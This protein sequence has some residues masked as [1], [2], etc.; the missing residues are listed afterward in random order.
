[1]SD[2]PETFF[3]RALAD[4]HL[5]FSIVMEARRRRQEIHRLRA[6]AG[7]DWREAEQ[8]FKEQLLGGI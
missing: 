7:A 2:T 5:K 1:M 8:W 3:E 6:E 4:G